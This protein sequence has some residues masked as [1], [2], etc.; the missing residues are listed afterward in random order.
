MWSAAT[1]EFLES[2]CALIVGSVSSDGEPFAARAWGLTI[3]ADDSFRLLLD[4]DDQGT[5][6]NL[7][8][9]GVIAITA[10][11]V[12]TLHSMQMK[13][14][15]DRFE[16]ATD[17]DHERAARYCEEFFT[18]IE[19]TDGSERRLLER[20]RPAGFVA[21]ILTVG[22]CFDQTPGPAAGSVLAPP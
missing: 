4:V 12:P 20:L 9:T 17:A 2:G 1:K 21:C 11:N 6:T 7:D 16:P 5:M 15:C 22:E 3:A 10:T 8:D 14:C 13:G 19:N 18:D